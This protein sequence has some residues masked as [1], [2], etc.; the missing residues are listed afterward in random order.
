MPF[1]Y[2]LISVFGHG[3]A[4]YGSLA[5]PLKS[6]RPLESLDHFTLKVAD[7]LISVRS[8]HKDLIEQARSRY[9][10][11]LS[12]QTEGEY[13]VWVQETPEQFGPQ[14]LDEP[15]FTRFSSEGSLRFVVSN[16]F[17]GTFDSGSNR[18]ELRVG[19]E[20]F[21]MLEHFL[22]ALCAWLC[23]RSDGLLF[24][25]AAV[26]KDHQSY[27]FFGTSGSGK[28][29]AARLSAQWKVIGDDLVVLKRIAGVWWI[30]GTPFNQEA[31]VANLHAPVRAF[32]RLVKAPYLSLSPIGRSQALAEFLA[33][34]PVVTQ[35]PLSLRIAIDLY[36][37][38]LD[39]VPCYRLGFAIDKSFWSDL[40]EHLRRISR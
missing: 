16:Q 36:S 21:S 17:T 13:T 4:Q 1:V 19:T 25:S 40:D 35:D 31:Y 3:C 9:K 7:L 32:F 22:R 23:I 30:Y 10:E 28:T 34:T 33:N 37:D 29:T 39:R 5:P 26:V 18:A 38:I 24:H 27:A 6:R 20:S 8:P 14:R 15:Y 11:F 12:D 2:V